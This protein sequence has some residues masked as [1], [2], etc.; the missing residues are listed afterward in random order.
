VD[1]GVEDLDVGIALD[2]TRLDL[3]RALG[4]EVDRLG[5]ADVELDRD[6]LEIQDQI[7]RVLDHAGD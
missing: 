7:D 4:L 3:A 5:V 2:V 6:L 1:L